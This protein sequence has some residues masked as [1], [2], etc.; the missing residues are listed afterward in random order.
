[1]KAIVYTRYGAPEVLKLA[2]VKK[3]QPHPNE[4]LIKICATTVTA[5]DFRVRSFTVPLLYWLPARIILGLFKPKINILG[6]EL[7]GVVESIGSDVSKFQPGDHVYAATLQGFGAYAEYKCI[8][9]DGPVA[10]KPS[11][12]SFAQAAALPIGARTALHYLRKVHILPGQKV[13][14]YGASGSVGT[15]AV[16]L[17][18]YF[19]GDVTGVCSAANLELVRSLGANTVIDYNKEDFSKR[20]KLYDVIF[21]AVDKSSFSACIKS[22]K[23]G[24]TYLNITMPVP[25]PRMLYTKIFSNKKI[26]LG[27]DSPETAMDL[28]II[29]NLVEAGDL[30]PVID[31]CY[32]MEN[33]IASH[34]Y[35]DKGHKRGNVVITLNQ[36]DPHVLNC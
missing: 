15:Y 21:V 25:S 20:G 36:N 6:M 16:Q 10:I 7:S 4:L 27:E 13:L 2:N 35:V 8:P 22:L 12:L 1:M 19:G 5:A 32:P 33:I 14:I 17:A 9:E 29:K 11:T 3:P 30:K 26:V 24:G 34:H 23:S 31:K 28:N 18:K